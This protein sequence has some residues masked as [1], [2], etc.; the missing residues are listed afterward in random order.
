MKKI[1][2][3]LG[4]LFLDLTAFLIS[5]TCVS[6][7]WFN[8]GFNI[9]FDNQTGKSLAN[10]FASGDGTIK[11]PYTITESIHFYNFA[12]LQYLGEFNKNATGTD[13]I[14]QK[15]FRLDKDI[16]MSDIV[17]PPVGTVT[18]PFVGS[19]DGNNKT[20]NNL[21]V[22]NTFNDFGAK[23]PSV[24][25]A[26]NFETIN[27]VGTFGVV[28]NLSTKF[29]YDT[30]I[31]EIKDFYLDN[32][33][34]KTNT[35]NL[36]VGIFAGYVNGKINNC[37][38]HYSKIEIANKTQ[39]YLTNDETVN[40]YINKNISNYTL[41]GAYN[42]A[43]YYWDGEP[44]FSEGGNDFGGSIDIYNLSRRIIKIN[45]RSD[46][47]VNTDVANFG[48][49]NQY[50][51][52]K[53]NTNIVSNISNINNY[54]SGKAVSLNDGTFLPLN[55]DVNKIEQ[56]GDASLSNEPI[57][58]NNTGYIVG[59]GSDKNT[60]GGIK[61]QHVKEDNLKIRG[62]DFKN[63]SLEEDY[64]KFKVNADNVAF[65][66][67]DS[68]NKTTKKIKDAENR[69]KIND[70]NCIESTDAALSRYD[71]VKKD[72]IEL[73]KKNMVID[74]Q[75]ACPLL[76]FNQTTSLTNENI[77]TLDKAYICGSEPK[78]NYQV[79]KGGINFTLTKSGRLTF[80]MP[81][82][83]DAENAE[84]FDLYRVT[85][86]ENNQIISNKELNDVL[87][88]THQGLVPNSIYYCEI[89]LEKGDYFLGATHSKVVPYFMYLD[90]GASASSTTETR[91]ALTNVDFVDTTLVNGIEKLNKVHP[92]NLSKVAFK[93]S[94][95]FDSNYIYYFRRK[96]NTV[97][98]YSSVTA[99]GFISPSSTG[100]KKKA[101]SEA[102]ES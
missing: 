67:W 11:K 50:I 22:S 66:Y 7:S 79:Y 97:Y 100:E 42:N 28:G 73:L 52:E 78:I 31:N 87:P 88:K 49:Y 39:Y 20:I 34:L 92:T 75:F 72:I 71:D 29:K 57:L 101:S 80:V 16:N 68:T 21:T 94:G 32:V 76:F 41:L 59:S 85:R 6:L 86:N 35:S 18:Y 61:I 84:M 60:G 82:V 48:N 98:Y 3:F 4:V 96:G 25:N 12:W 90:I 83:R 74:E 77:V 95:T 70:S 17:V 47:H 8:K 9:K 65:S 19:F 24:V 51:N 23:H 102:C 99:F 89:P 15:Y 93:I 10:Y 44:G 38:V 37:G 91:T 33:T 69:K 63:F 64:S 30:K 2:L 26:G 5:S 45:S 1:S 54:E 58:S 81:T 55:V 14:N 40:G 36:L 56:Y 62:F 43:S 27:I 53:F 13:S 46:T